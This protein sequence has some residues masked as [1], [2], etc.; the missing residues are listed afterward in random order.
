MDEDLLHNLMGGSLFSGLGMRMGG[1]GGGRRRRQKGENTIHP[2]KVTLEDLYKGKTRHLEVQKK[3]IC[4]VCEGIGG[5]AG[6]VRQCN[7][8]HGTGIKATLHQI[9]PGM[10]QQTQS[11]C[12]ECQGEGEVINERERCK[13]CLG[14]KV[15]NEVKRLEVVVEPGMTPGKK[16]VFRG[17]GNQQPGVEPG[18]II[19]VLDQL[20]HK[21]FERNGNSLIY[22]YDIS[23]TEALCGCRIVITHLDGR[24]MAIGTELG[25]VIE[26][27]AIRT[28]V[29]GGMPVHKSPEEF[30][31]L[32]VKFNVTFPENHF[33]D[34]ET[35]SNLEKLLPPR[36]P[37]VAPTGEH[38]ED[39]DLNEMDNLPSGSQMDADD[40]DRHGAHMQCASH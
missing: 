36:I 3:V 16:I 18:D 20:A 9:A 6:A 28:V 8:C 39:A 10:V 37:F 2:L 12:P 31:D 22:K 25:D 15:V 14:K 34:E 23:L 26:P 11:H 19:I 33:G 35:F 4:S 7:N 13:T 32:Y 17:E 40:D 27:G 5:K 29:N 30:G 21:T 24:Q 38:V 1:G